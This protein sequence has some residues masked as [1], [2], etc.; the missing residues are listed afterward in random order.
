MNYFMTLQISSKSNQPRFVKWI[1][2]YLPG[3]KYSVEVDLKIPQPQPKSLKKSADKSYKAYNGG[4]GDEIIR[5][6]QK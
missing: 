2:F 4:W 5:N 6:N 1:Y 3:I